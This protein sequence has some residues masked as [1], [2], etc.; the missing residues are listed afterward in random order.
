MMP[1]RRMLI[2]GARGEDDFSRAAQL[3]VKYERDGF[4]SRKPGRSSLV[5]YSTK[6]ADNHAAVW[7]TANQITVHFGGERQ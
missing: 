5:I 6:G 4:L 7:H 1:K 3:A 2:I